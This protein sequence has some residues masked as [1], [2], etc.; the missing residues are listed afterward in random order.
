MKFLRA[1]DL[2]ASRLRRSDAAKLGPLHLLHIPRSMH[3][4]IY[5][6]VSCRFIHSRFILATF[7][8]TPISALV[9]WLSQRAFVFP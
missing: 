8:A 7:F 5:A 9:V 1:L 2:S 6:L 4:S 3:A